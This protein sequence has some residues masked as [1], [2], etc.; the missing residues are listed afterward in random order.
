M[1]E[2]WRCEDL[3]TLGV[4][5]IWNDV[6]DTANDRAEMETTRRPMF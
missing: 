2:Y 1:S 3:D 6:R 5:W 4:D